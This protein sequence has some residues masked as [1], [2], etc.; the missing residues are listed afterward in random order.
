MN[1]L[2]R[3]LLAVLLV[4]G[5]GTALAQAPDRSPALSEQITAQVREP[6]SQHKLPQVQLAVSL[7]RLMGAELGVLSGTGSMLPVLKYCDLAVSV[8]VDIRAVKIGDIVTFRGRYGGQPAVIIHR[9][10]ATLDGGAALRTQGDAV[11]FADPM[12]VTARELIG[13]VRYVVDGSTA[14]IRDFGTQRTGAEITYADIAQRLG[15]P[16]RA[17]LTAQN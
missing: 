9:V 15:T 5:T 14:Q 11:P 16:E 13:V 3:P 1:A 6:Y 2:S 8:P 17:R 4:L 7:A 10:V 12:P